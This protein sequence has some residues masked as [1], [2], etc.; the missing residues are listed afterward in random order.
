MITVRRASRLNGAHKGDGRGPGV[1]GQ[2]AND[3]ATV[4]VGLSRG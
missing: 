1:N 4:R 3:A 2:K